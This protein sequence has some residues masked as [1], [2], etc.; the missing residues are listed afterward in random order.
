VVKNDYTSSSSSS[1]LITKAAK[2]ACT[3]F[4]EDS[5]CL[6]VQV[7]FTDITGH[8]HRMKKK[9]WKLIQKRADPSDFFGILDLSKIKKNDEIQRK[10][11]VWGISVIKSQRGYLKHASLLGS[12]KAGKEPETPLWMERR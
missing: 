12:A 1:S 5:W 8:R 2:N 4:R 7:K 11:K 9:W 10:S 3:L 6:K